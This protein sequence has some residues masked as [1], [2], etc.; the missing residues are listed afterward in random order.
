MPDP[1]YHVERCN[2]LYYFAEW[3]TPGE[4]FVTCHNCPG[5][6]RTPSLHR[7][8]CLNQAAKGL[9]NDESKVGSL[10]TGKASAHT[11]G[12]ERYSAV[13][14]NLHCLLLSFGY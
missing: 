1:S 7:N 5:P 8:C 11:S 3:P 6:S 12:S 2:E 14:S 4:L 13:V 10:S 9:L